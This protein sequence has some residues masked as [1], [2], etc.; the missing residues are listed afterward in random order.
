MNKYVGSSSSGTCV[1]NINAYRMVD[2]KVMSLPSFLSLSS[3]ADHTL[4]ILIVSSLGLT[5]NT[6]HPS[7]AIQEWPTGAEC[8]LTVT[9]C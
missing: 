8:A 9:I 2:L 6:E 7:G 3:G 1:E 5:V 4:N